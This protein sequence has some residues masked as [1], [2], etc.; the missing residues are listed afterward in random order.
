M[1][2]LSLSWMKLQMHTTSPLSN[3][4][5][6]FGSLHES[7]QDEYKAISYWLLE[8]IV[9]TIGP[10]LCG[11]LRKIETFCF[12]IIWLLGSIEFTHAISPI[13]LT[14]CASG[15]SLLQ[16]SLFNR[17]R[18]FSKWKQLKLSTGPKRRTS[19]TRWSKEWTF[20]VTKCH[21]TTLWLPVQN[22]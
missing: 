11:F 20:M 5:Q 16:I 19:S 22:A 12:G 8:G 15:L 6:L 2:V 17:W 7:N 13:R 10:P 18:K 1:K 9:Y 4:T 14:S 3:K 21:H